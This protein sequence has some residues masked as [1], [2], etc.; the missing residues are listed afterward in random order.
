MALLAGAAAW[1]Q[2]G[3]D[4]G[5]VPASSDGEAAAP[6]AGSTR[7]G[8]GGGAGAAVASRDSWGNAQAAADATDGGV[9]ARAP[10]TSGDSGGN[11]QASAGATDGG[12]DAR[13]VAARAPE[14]AARQALAARGL[15][16]VP[17]PAWTLE[18]L[19]DLQAG[20]EA[21]PPRARAFPGGPLEVALHPE[22][23]TAFGLGDGAHPGLS[24]DGRR[25]HL[26][27]YRD[28][29]D[30]ARA[31]ARLKHLSAAQRERLWRRRAVVHAVLHRW[32][33][34]L[35]WSARAGWR[36]LSGWQGQR[37]LLVYPWAFSRRG[38]LASPAAD[39]ATF[40]E[41]LLVAPDGQPADDSARCRA[42]SK[43]RY[44]DE[45]L[46]A[47]DASWRPSRACPAF[48]AWADVAHLRGFEVLFA[49]PS[50]VSAQAVFGHLLLRVVR[51]DDE[52]TAGAGRVMQLAALVS[53]LEPKGSYLLRGLGGGFRGVF[54]LTSLSDVRFEALGLQQRALRRFALELTAEE[55]ERLL[56]R[57]W[58]L[59]RVGYLDYRFFTANCAT[60]LRFL[61][62][63]VLDDDAPGPPWTPWEMPTQVLDALAPR[64]RALP[65]EETSGEQALRADAEVRALVAHPPPGVRE[66]FGEAWGVLQGVESTSVEARV[67]AARVL[68]APRGG[69]PEEWRARVALAVLRWERFR[70]DVAT[71]ERILAERAA[72]L[73]GWTGPTTDELVAARQ[74]RFEAQATPRERLHA[75]L[76]ELLSLEALLRTAPRRALTPSEAAV[77][78]D[79]AQAR[80]AFEEAAEVVAALPQA[81]LDEALA[82][83]V[84]AQRRF[85]AEAVARAVPE[86][87]HLHA[88]AGAGASS[89]AGALV[90]LR[91]AALVEQLGDQRHGGF[92]ARVGVRALDG[93][94]EVSPGP[95]PAVHRVGVTLLSMQ[96]LGAGGW[97][98]GAGVD[99]RYAV[100]AHEVVVAG[101]GLRL[102]AADGR[103]TNYLLA[104]AGGR[105]GAQVRDAAALLVAP[106]AGLEG[107]VQ[108][109]GSFA[110]AVRLQAEWTPQVVVGAGPAAFAHGVTARGSVVVRLGVV[111]RVAV[112]VCADGEVAWRE[113]GVVA[114]QGVVGVTLD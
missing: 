98:W 43:A 2:P 19:E 85:E 104:R 110:N 9:D 33:E 3:D 77:V 15:V 87:G 27:G 47:L 14:D 53:P 26:Y 78:A 17:S 89:T 91:A 37:A 22:Q 57:V 83:E 63:A 113:G 39:L 40:A 111:R 34:A 55:R 114:G 30:D 81:A 5:V 29:G 86:G 36:R 108:L 100:R 44:L 21:L 28:D 82:A 75:E 60:M 54:S 11:A 73:P 25:L 6:A 102:L 96:A 56:A 99:W 105:V 7:D 103:L 84:A 67:R 10:A 74:R 35:R 112:S 1:A 32:D 79:E 65:A 52:A 80:E 69:V 58:E 20:V 46:A 48:D 97:G 12:I 8:G 49:A 101:D 93:H 50:A 109:P 51:D 38:G 61:V 92:G 66:A 18:L 4:P 59:E 23:V 16:V 42:P 62:E 31:M 68:G 72:I 41:E 24:G 70:L 71:R 94:L 88:F 13:A 107:R 64:L 95:T 45:R 90:R 76:A 106:V